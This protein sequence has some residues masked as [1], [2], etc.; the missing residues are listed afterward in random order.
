VAHGRGGGVDVES[1]GEQHDAQHAAAASAAAALSARAGTPHNPPRTP[2]LSK[3]LRHGARGGGAGGAAAGVVGEAAPTR[4]LSPPA[5]LAGACWIC[6]SA[7]IILLNKKVLSHYNFTAVNC[8]LAYHGAIAVALLRAAEAAGLVEI[9]PL[10]REVFVIWLPLNCIFVGMLATA[11]KALG[12]VRR[13]GVGV[14]VGAGRAAAAGGGAGRA[15]G[16]VGAAAACSAPETRASAARR[17][18][19]PPLAPL[20]LGVGVM[21][22]LKNLTNIFIIAGDYM[23]MGRTYT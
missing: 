6:C 22:L 17:D 23:M 8:L 19:R 5:L 14:W 2:S 20:Q 18:R 1:S 21:S 9:T 13:P 7:S 4:A 10:T 11:F 3:L 12:L 15:H 16:A